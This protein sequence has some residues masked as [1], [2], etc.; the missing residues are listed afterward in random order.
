M[1]TQI[2]GT[3]AFYEGSRRWGTL[4]ALSVDSQMTV[5]VVDA[6]LLGKRYWA[7]RGSGAFENGRQL[8][9]SPTPTLRRATISDNY[10]DDIE[11]QTKGQP[12]YKLSLHCGTVL[13]H[14]EYSMLA[15]A[16]GRADVA[17]MTAGGPWDYAPFVVI[18][19]EAGGRASDQIGS[20]WR[21]DSFLLGTNGHVHGEALDAL[22]NSSNNA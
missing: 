2:D 11:R 14:R 12:L 10:R 16:T 8:A 22:A 18:V 1:S 7:A 21:G 20:D 15:V 19:E 9:V 17:L 4:I 3:A 6:P 5:G 13:P